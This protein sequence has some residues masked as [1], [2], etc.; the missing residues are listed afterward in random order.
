MGLKV[1]WRVCVS[2]NG[3]GV[4]HFAEGMGITLGTEAGYHQLSALLPDEAAQRNIIH[5]LQPFVNGRL[6]IAERIEFA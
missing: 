4:H 2:E 6:H 1:S 3:E 5:Q